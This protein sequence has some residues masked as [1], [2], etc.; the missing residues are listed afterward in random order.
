MARAACPASARDVVVP[1]RLVSSP[2]LVSFCLRGEC[3]WALTGRL[4]PDH[5]VRTAYSGNRFVFPTILLCI[6]HYI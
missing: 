1:K 3:L 2:M 4:L 6:D 5:K